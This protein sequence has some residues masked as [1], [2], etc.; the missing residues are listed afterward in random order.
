MSIFPDRGPQY[1]RA[2]RDREQA[3]QEEAFRQRRLLP[4][5]FKPPGWRPRR[6]LVYNPCTMSDS[7]L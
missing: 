3:K 5:P 6:D 7:Y 1:D 4:R 2:L